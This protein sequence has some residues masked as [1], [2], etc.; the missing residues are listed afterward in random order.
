MAAQACVC[1]DNK[2]VP[3][4]GGEKQG[5]KRVDRK[6]ERSDIS[7]DIKFVFSRWHETRRGAAPSSLEWTVREPSRG[8]Q[9]SFDTRE[10]KGRRRP[11][12]LLLWLRTYACMYAASAYERGKP[13]LKRGGVDYR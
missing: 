6:V 10:S 4:S 11:T 3:D 9:R 2:T 7:R 5:T 13:V 8:E 12:R 1:I